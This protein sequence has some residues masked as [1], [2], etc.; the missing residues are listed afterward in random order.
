M[1]AFHDLAWRAVQKGRPNDP[2]LLYLVARA[3]SLSG[4]PGDALVMIDRLTA[5]R[6]AT[7]AATDD[8]LSRM[9][10]L[11]GWPA[12]ADRI[13]AVRAGHP[14]GPALPAPTT[15]VSPAPTGAGSRASSARSPVPTAA[16]DTGDA[17]RFAIEEPRPAGL[18]YDVVSR[19]FV[20][21]SREGRKLSVVDEFSQH[22]ATLSGTQA[23]FDD[24]AALDL[25]PLVRNLW[26][27]SSPARAERRRSTSCARLG[28]RAPTFQPAARPDSA[29]FVDVAV[30]GR[31]I[32]LVLDGPGK[33]L[34]GFA[35]DLDL[36]TAAALGDTDAVS[37]A[38][39]AEDVVYLAGSHG[40]S[41]VDPR[42]R[43]RPPSKRRRGRS[44]G[45]SRIRFYRGGLVG[46]Q[47]AGSSYRAVGSRSMAAA[48]APPR[49]SRSI[50][51]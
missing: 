33:R 11:P 23:G 50:R 18:A 39:A 31:S 38:P 28:A 9:R 13:A 14:P 29:R 21:A 42:P 17:A 7:D 10:A 19:R 37:L 24:I 46:L 25:D 51:R 30:S 43:R 26:V 41:R 5:M 22:V 15:S 8:D 12:L 44:P 49:S 34:C 1:R 32:V 16:T 4:R 40:I 48:V 27:V 45:L 36:E 20:V 6:V 2:A 35:L 47:Q 3:Q